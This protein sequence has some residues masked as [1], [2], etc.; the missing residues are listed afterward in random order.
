MTGAGIVDLRTRAVNYRVSLQLGEGIAVPIQVS[1]T[2]D[3]LSYQPDLT[4]ILA[5]T[6]GNMLTILKSAGGSVSQGL[7]GIGQGA[8]GALKGI[9]GK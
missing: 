6:P 3:H 5:Q 1:G 9:F 2:W 7:R 4:A 8:V